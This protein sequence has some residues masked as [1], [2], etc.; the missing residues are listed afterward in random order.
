M[1]DIV[2]YVIGKKKGGIT[3]T[4]QNKEITITENGEQTITADSGYDGLSSVSVTTNVGG[5]GPKNVAELNNALKDLYDGFN[6][7]VNNEYNN[8]KTAYT[9]N[10]INIYSP[11]ENCKKYLITKTNGGKYQIHWVKNYLF[12]AYGGTLT[13]GNFVNYDYYSSEINNN[14]DLI[15]T[16]YGYLTGYR[17]GQWQEN[18]YVSKTSYDTVEEAIS[19]I[20]SNE[21]KY[22]ATTGETYYAECLYSNSAII[23]NIQTDC[24]FVEVGI[25]SH[26]ET[27][28]TI[29]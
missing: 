2:S 4:Y 16:T 3:P 21:T 7:Y 15:N 8:T 25:I 19:A 11:H 23:D 29:S 24:K 20:Q 1:D 27:I 12:L 28:I 9:D 6:Y 13:P 18:R 10:N 26:N 17:N 22:M 5:G 14:G